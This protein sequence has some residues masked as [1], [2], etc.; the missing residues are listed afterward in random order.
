MHD[1]VHMYTLGLL[2]RARICM[3]RC[4]FVSMKV[5]VHFIIDVLFLVSG[6]KKKKKIHKN[7]YYPTVTFC[8]TGFNFS[9][10]YMSALETSAVIVCD[11]SLFGHIL[12]LFDVYMLLYCGGN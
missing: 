7:N 1:V 2:F 10:W 6:T 9:A 4:D 11:L 5:S 3:Q 12:F 8:K